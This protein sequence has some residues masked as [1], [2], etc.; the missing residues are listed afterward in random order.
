MCFQITICVS[1]L[2]WFLT[3][4]YLDEN[5]LN[6]WAKNSHRWILIRFPVSGFLQK[7]D[8]LMISRPV[9]EIMH[10]EIET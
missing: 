1:K 4:G 3:L 2:V 7:F 8:K 5:P 6:F 10:F 9:T